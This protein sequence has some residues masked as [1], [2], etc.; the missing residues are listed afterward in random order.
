MLAFVFYCGHSLPALKDACSSEKRDKQRPG[1]WYEVV[2]YTRVFYSV[3]GGG[4]SSPPPSAHLLAEPN[5][6][7]EYATR[8]KIKENN[9]WFSIRILGALLL[10]NRSNRFLDSLTGY[11]QPEKTVKPVFIF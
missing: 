10:K 2:L 8:W 1:T 3:K 5:T 9:T 4:A 7:W 11:K 6:H